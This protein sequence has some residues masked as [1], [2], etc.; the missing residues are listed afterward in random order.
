MAA[1]TGA[2]SDQQQ[3]HPGTPLLPLASAQKFTNQQDS[4]ITVDEV[5]RL[6]DL[7]LGRGIDATN[8]TP[9]KNKSSFQVRE[10]SPTLGNIIGTEEGGAHQYYENEISSVTS[11]QANVKLSV[12]EPH[13]KVKI[14]M[15]GEQ[16]RS[17]SKVRKAAGEKVITRTISFRADFDDLPLYCVDN[18]ASIT[19]SSKTPCIHTLSAIATPS[20]NAAPTADGPVN[21]T[22][23]V[24]L[25]EWILDRIYARQDQANELQ[26]SSK[27]EGDGQTPFNGSPRND[28]PVANL[29]G[30][31]P[32]SKLSD[33]LRSIPKGSTELQEIARDCYE[34]VSLLGITHYVYAIELGAVK[35]RVFT[36]AEYQKKYGGGG[37]LG[38]EGIVELSASGSYGKKNVT[39]STRAREIGKI[40]KGTV[41]RGT[42]D[43]AVIGIE[44][45][46]IHKLVQL[47]YIHL[48]M[49]QALKDYINE[50]ADKSGE[51]SSITFKHTHAPTY[52]PTHT[53]TQ[54]AH[55]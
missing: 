47:R 33:Y 44:I 6:I 49:Q 55:S 48:A 27:K 16:S 29:N 17:V 7:G 1:S 26:K 43:E 11:Q 10:I 52:T 32:V 13:G 23:E 40:D 30:D 38:V 24:R 37:N 5:Q 51:T 28:K 3:Q 35:Y 4:V 20:T 50:R 9:W 39:K 22:F 2:T 19:R 36:L 41:Q 21:N 15:D 12:N 14:G 31:T 46:P 53:H 45:K 54:R 18:D 8:P 34:F 25:C 42:R